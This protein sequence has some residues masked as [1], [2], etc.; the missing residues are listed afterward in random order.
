MQ[1]KLI[2]LILENQFGEQIIG[3]KIVDKKNAKIFINAVKALEENQSTFNFNNQDYTWNRE[4]YEIVTINTSEAKILDKLFSIE[5][6]VNES[7][8]IGLF[9]DPIEQAYEQG[10]MDQDESQ[11][12][13]DEEQY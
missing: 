6:S 8:S 13:Y 2:N 7:N 9:P 1:L 10:L 11:E 3:F 12:E 5:F 4:I